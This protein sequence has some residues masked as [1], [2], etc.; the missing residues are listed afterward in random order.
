[1][2]QRSSLFY[3]SL[4]LTQNILLGVGNPIAKYGM[5]SFPFF[6]YVA[7]R[8]LMGSLFLILLFH[9]KI[10]KGMKTSFWMPGT[11]IAALNAGAY[12]L[13]TLTF[14]YTTATSAGFLFALP[15]IFTPFLMRFISK[16]KIEKKKYIPICIVVAGTY[17]LCCGSGGFVFGPGEAMAVTSSFLVA[18]VFEFSSH[19]LEHME[20]L[21]LAAYQ[22]GFTGVVCLVLGIANNEVM[23][24]FTGVPAA[25]WGA[26]V[27]LG[28]G[29]TG[30]SYCLQNFALSKIDS[31]KA[32]LIM[33][34]QPVFTTA[35]SFVLLGERM[36]GLQTAGAVIIMG[37]IIY[38]NVM[39]ES[40]PC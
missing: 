8:F 12:I 30:I 35:A 40:K 4:I 11:L 10:F 32:A 26:L 37:G 25:A 23:P 3:G 1:M 13:G 22:S 20:P 31:T 16:V 18:C 2:K 9:K 39:P 5:S 17:L 24:A 19:Y 27:Y 29:C 14:K 33:C 15:V 38:A 7:V 6:L 21:L 36:A 28:I 34:S